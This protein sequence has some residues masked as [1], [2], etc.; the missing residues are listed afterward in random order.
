MKE[1]LFTT[2]FARD[3]E[4]TESTEGLGVLFSAERAENKT[5]PALRGMWKKISAGSELFFSLPSSQRN[6]KEKILLCDLCA[7]VVKST[8]FR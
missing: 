1:V 5:Q 7:S 4:S 3:T 6:E 2:R 8:L